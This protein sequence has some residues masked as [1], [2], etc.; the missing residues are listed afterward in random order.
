MPDPHVPCLTLARRGTGR[1]YLYTALVPFG[2]YVLYV[3]L[4]ANEERLPRRPGFLLA[5]SLFFILKTLVF[6][7]GYVGEW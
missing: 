6:I 2:L 1:V 4:V 3:A 5:P 7:E